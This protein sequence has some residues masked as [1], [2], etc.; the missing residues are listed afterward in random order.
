[1]D[2]PQI[3]ALIDNIFPFE[4][5]LYYQILP[6]SVEGSRIR[7]GVVDPKDYSGL[8]YARRLLSYL[9]CSL[10]IE[11][12]SC[13]IQR[14]TL[15]SYLSHIC[16]QEHKQT[17]ALTV[18]LSQDNQQKIDNSQYAKIWKN[19]QFSEAKNSIDQGFLMKDY[20]NLKQTKLQSSSKKSICNILELSLPSSVNTISLETIITLNPQKLLKELLVKVLESGI[21]RISFEQ[22]QSQ[23]EIFWSQ[24]GVLKSV[25]KNLEP[26]KIKAIINELKILTKMSLSP[27]QK[28]RQVEIE[29]IYKNNHILLCL[30]IVPGNYGEKATKQIGRA[31]V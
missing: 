26:K 17:S 13:E 28:P 25:V 9:N 5:C 19:K 14:S 18:S 20:K 29:R 11:E 4:A 30:R 21:G 15:S 7:L 22:Q 10:I 8:D 24:D 6:L 16:H 12:I 31:H 3:F 1:M 23:G 27:I 2:N